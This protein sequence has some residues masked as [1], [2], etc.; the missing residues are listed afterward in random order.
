MSVRGSETMT[1][2]LTKTPN[3]STT[4]TKLKGS[5]ASF[6]AL[7]QSGKALGQLFKGQKPTFILRQGETGS[8]SMQWGK[9][10]TPARQ[11]PERGPK[12]TNPI[13]QNEH[14][15]NGIR[16][17]DTDMDIGAEISWDDKNGNDRVDANER[18]SASVHVYGSQLKRLGQ[19]GNF[20]NFSV[21]VYDSAIP[22][23]IIRHN[24]VIVQSDPSDANG[25]IK[26][27]TSKNMYGEQRLDD[28][29]KTF[30]ADFLDG[31]NGK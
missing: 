4:L 19:I 3:L 22:E 27:R 11:A 20:K 18:E 6:K 25:N 23:T 29:Q 26:H 14:V 24:H 12:M 10:H 8:K 13:D 15:M 28:P 2:A 16:V 17:G 1:P 9:F 31:L 30:R 21:L 5:E 7:S